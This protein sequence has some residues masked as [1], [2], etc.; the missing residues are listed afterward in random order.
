MNIADW[1][2]RKLLK[3]VAAVQVAILG[4]VALRAMALDIPGLRYVVGFIYLTFIPGVLVLRILRWHGLSLSE[5]LLYCVGLSLAILMLGG[6]AMNALFPHIGIARPISTTPLLLT[7]S[8]VC[9]GL[10]LVAYLRDRGYRG[11]SLAIHW[12]GLFSP[13]VLMLLLFPVLSILGVSLVNFN[14]DNRLLIAMLALIALVAALVALGKFIP[15]RLFP[16]AVVA[17]AISLLFHTSLNSAGLT[18]TDIRVE[19][20]MYKVVATNGYW[21]STMPANAFNETLSVTVLPT[22]YSSLL[23][24][25]GTWVFKVIFPLC[26]SLVALA[27]YQACRREFGERIG[28]WAAFYFASFFQFYNMMLE[29]GKMQIAELF[30]CLLALLMV[31]PDKYSTRSKF[32]FVMFGAGMVVSHYG[33]AY[34]Y[35]LIMVLALAIL[36]V[37]KHRSGFLNLNAILLLTVLALSWYLFNG[38]S[39]VMNTITAL[40]SHFYSN[41]VAEFFSPSAREIVVFA[42]EAVSTPIRISN[43]LLNYAAQLFIAIGLIRM[44]LQRKLLR[45]SEEY[46][47]FSI[48]SFVMLV[49]CVLLPFFSR[50]IG[51]SR[52]YSLTLIFLA[53]AC[54]LGGQAIFQAILRVLHIFQPIREV[55]SLKAASVFLI[56]FFLFST[57]FA[58]A[59]AHD[60]PLS[61]ALDS[62]RDYPRFT[63][64]EISGAQWLLDKR[65]QWAPLSSD[66]FG[67]ALFWAYLPDDFPRAFTTGHNTTAIA[68]QPKE[69]YVFL[70]SSTIRDR[71][72][73][74]YPQGSIPL[75]N[76]NLQGEDKIFDSGG[77]QIYYK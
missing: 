49:V 56:V 26:F 46:I 16:L 21:N 11:T 64:Q 30:F 25:D 39:S 40:G 54:V 10:S 50:M 53:P 52:L 33:T 48:A 69:G 6:A 7:I 32:L 44:V 38:G 37:A 43:S 18:G 76:L 74:L 2:I 20:Y 55:F 62:H 4:L 73:S 27:V 28:F 42:T 29:L 14:G 66:Y 45:F 15:S 75:E 51:T 24:L 8:I 3:A 58:Y 72:L 57:R 22:I 36:A 59:L 41:F 61:I 9:L 13:P 12:R 17:I 70:R 65:V 23:G 67:V 60:Y 71:E 77:V 34:T 35:L 31:S 19:Y 63:A 1:E 68:N 47:A 5:T